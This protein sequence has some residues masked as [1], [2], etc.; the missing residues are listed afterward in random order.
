MIQIV[1]VLAAVTQ[2]DSAELFKAEPVPVEGFTAG[3]EGPACDR[4]GNLYAVAYQKAENIARITPEGAAEVFITLPHGSCGNGIVFD[5]AGRMFVADYVN[6]NVL[7]IDPQTKEV[8]VHASDPRMHQ[9]N[10]LAIAE[11]GAIYASDPDWDNSRGQVWRISPEGK[12]ELFISDLGTANGIE[13]SP[14][15]KTLY[16][17]E[18][19]QRNVWAFDL[20]SHPP[21][22]KLLKQFPDFGLD[23]M[24]CDV[25]GNLYIARWGK[26]TVV[27]LSPAGKELQEVEVLGAKPSNVCFGGADGRSVFVTEMENKRLVTFQA[28]QPGLSWR[29]LQSADE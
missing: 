19:V 18:S 22:K 14:D 11:D 15:G 20:T 1:F 6:H 5:R 7:R 27:K 8:A 26:G 21:A 17:N 9:P 25:D 13:V 24:R 12:C 2:L 28:D 4:V 16:V 23:G 29:R 10:D 3:I